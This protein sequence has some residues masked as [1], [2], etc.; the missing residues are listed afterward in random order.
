MDGYAR[1]IE[2]IRSEHDQ[3]MVESVKQRLI[4]RV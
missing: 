2:R 4:S 3:H 1:Q